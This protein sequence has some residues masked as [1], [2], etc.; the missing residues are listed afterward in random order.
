MP[1][2]LKILVTINAS[3]LLLAWSGI[4]AQSYHFKK[5]QVENGLSNNTVSCILQDKKG[6]LWVGTRDGLNRFDGYNFKVFRFDMNNPKSLSGDFV[7]TIQ[8]TDNGNIWIGTDKGLFEYHPED[9]T[10]NML[11]DKINYVRDIKMDKDGKLWFI[12][13]KTFYTGLTLCNYNSHT[14]QIHKIPQSDNSNP[15]SIC[16]S[17]DG[18]LWSSTSNGYI[19]KFDESLNSFSRFPVFDSTETSLPKTI[20]KIYYIGKNSFLIGTSHYGLKFFNSESGSWKNLQIRNPDKTPLFVRDI[21]KYSEEEY[22]I[23]TESGVFIYNINTGKYINLRK[24]YNDPFSISNNSVYALTKDKEGGVWVGTF[25]GGL[26]YFPKQYNLFAK[27]FPKYGDNSLRG[28]IV[29]EIC[30]DKYGNFWIGTEDAGLNK[31]D[32]KTGSFQHF[33]PTGSAGG[34]SYHNI[35]GLKVIDNNLWIGTYEH[36]L[37]I[38]N[39]NNNKVIRHYSSGSDSNSFKSNFIVTIFQT[40]NKEILIGTYSGLYKYNKSNDNFSIIKDVP[41]DAFVY[42]IYEDHSGTIWVGTIGDGIYYFN[43]QRKEKGNINLKDIK[44]DHRIRNNVISIFEDS[45]HNLWFATEGSGVSLYNTTAKSF[46]NYSTKNGLPSNLIF[47]ILEDSKKRIWMTTSKGLVCFDPFNNNTMQIYTTANGILNSQFNYNSG[48]QDAQGVLYFGSLGGMI[49]FKP[50]N[51]LPEH[52]I[53]DLYI[54]G[55]QINNAEVDIA[56]KNSPLKKSVINTTKLTLQHN[57]SSLSFDFAAI[58][59][60]APEMT[61]YAFQLEGLDNTWTYLK[62]NRRVYFTNLSPGNYIFKVKTVN[63]SGEKYSNERKFEIKILSPWWATTWAYSLYIVTGLVIII[64]L[65][66]SYKNRL[67]LKHEIKFA[68]HEYEKEKEILQSKFDFFTNVAHEIRTPLT[69]IV[70]PL[71]KI[72]DETSDIPELKKSL[73]FMERNTNQLL[74]LT[75]QLLDF[76]KTEIKGFSLS[77]FRINISGLLKETYESFKSLAEGKKVNYQ[78]SFPGTTVYADA[79][80]EAIQKILNNLFSNAIKYAKTI[81]HIKLIAPTKTEK[82]FII[83]LSNDGY[84]IPAEMQEKIFEPF[85]RISENDNQN[86]TGIGLSISRSLTELHKGVIFCKKSNNNLNTFVLKIPADRSEQNPEAKA[87]Y[88]K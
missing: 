73:E 36:G 6:F 22:W 11:D 70:G 18:T 47:K 69:L 35:H 65:F 72:I 43:T 27:Y 44:K 38:M 8:E 62:S 64:F 55:I 59:F 2:I 52:F 13:G 79:D 63:D 83:E 49:S 57:Q 84:L 78:I 37:D 26:N 24:D 50:E 80:I 12:T 45:N 75:N 5:Y 23:A 53:P 61:Q 29:R 10:F 54:T 51:F 87:K 40:T 56:V 3:L 39:I 82:S 31:L 4:K 32:P 7:H 9:E 71:E 17:E 33:E 58:N 15:T 16:I 85:Y 68:R 30:Q 41:S 60:S 48:Y 77:F 66:Q 25:F 42:S 28:N 86:G 88:V 46:T 67:K 1:S 19:E 74:N 20:E 21:L 34:I 76:R 81:V 14:R